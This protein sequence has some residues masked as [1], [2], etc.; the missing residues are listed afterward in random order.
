MIVSIDIETTG[1]DPEKHKVLEIAAVWFVA[2]VEQVVQCYVK[3]TEVYG[4]LY[5]LN[6]NEK[7]IERIVNGEGIEESEVAKFFDSKLPDFYT[8]AGAN[9]ANFDLRFLRKLGWEPKCHHR[10]IDVG[11]LYW[12][13]TI[14]GDNLPSMQ[15][16]LRRARIPG[17]VKHNAV[18]DAKDVLKLIGVKRC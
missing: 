9:F 4:H 6:M 7:A 5:A 10:I 2:G 8:A 15:E 18:D 12:D 14:D 17:N 1:L 3:Q 11:N 13:P 16:C